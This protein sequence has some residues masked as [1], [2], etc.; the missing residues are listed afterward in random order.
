MDFYPDAPHAKLKTK[1][2]YP[3]FP[4]IPAPLAQI[5]ERIDNILTKVDRIPF[6][7]IGE[8]LKVAV[9]ELSATLA[10]IKSI[11]GKVN[12]ETI[13][14]VNAA[15]ENLQDVMQGIE[16]TLGP[17]SALN[18]NA[19]TVTDELSMA[20]RSIRSLLEYLE[21]NPQALILGKEGGKK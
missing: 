20:I 15:L 10:E 16:S 11:S 9:K 21:R 6:G 3:V 5:V 13:P 19:R 14:K 17:D 2:S 7:Q 12:L 18:Y 1:G 4:T 8:D